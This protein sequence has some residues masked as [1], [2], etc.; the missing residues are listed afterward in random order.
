MD[1]AVARRGFTTFEDVTPAAV[2][3]ARSAVERWNADDLDAVY[4]DWH[5]ELTVR[6]DP[7]FPDAGE[8]V[9]AP[10]ARRFFEDQRRFMGAGRLQILEEHD[11]GERCLVRIRQNVDAPASGV[12][13]SY[14]WG[15]LMTARAGKV[16][17]IEFFIGR[18][19]A[20]RAA[21]VLPG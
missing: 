7:N 9:G 16:I 5:P 10:A 14:D 17:R 21:G 19:Q 2:E 6:P 12:H 8:L 15:L 13:S 18:E 3:L 11:L 1:P 20:L 4:A